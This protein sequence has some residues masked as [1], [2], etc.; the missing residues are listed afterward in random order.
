[1]LRLWKTTHASILMRTSGIHTACVAGLLAAGCSALFTAR[2]GT[3][4]KED[5]EVLNELKAPHSSESQW[6]TP[7]L[8]QFGS[9]L[10]AQK[11]P[12]ADAQKVY[13]LAE[14][15]DLA[16]RI[17]P[18]TKVAWEQARQ[19]ASAIGLAQ[20]DYYP[21]L[22]LQAAAN[23]EREP[24]PIPLTPTKGTFMDLE[25][26]QASPVATLEWVLLDF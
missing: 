12:E 8:R 4:F 23:Y 20:S 18:E 25:A 22:A 2:A 5:S 16:E 3:P 26:Q 6:Q 19:A 15:V 10:T 7:D 9:E 17:N 24:I 21:A 1:M 13:E 14:L 11:E